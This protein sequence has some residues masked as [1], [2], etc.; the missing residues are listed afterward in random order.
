MV[1]VDLSGAKGFFDQ[2]GL[3]YAAAASAHRAL[4]DGSGAG[5]EFTGWLELPHM[6]KNGELKAI[7]SAADKIQ[8]HSDVLVVIGIGGSYLGARA[9]I[10]LLSSPNHNLLKG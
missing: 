8:S 6:I 5:N 2:S 1:K 10:E 7:I 3:D 4:C 9:S